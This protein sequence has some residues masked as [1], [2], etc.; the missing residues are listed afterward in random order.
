[1]NT[2][3]RNPADSSVSSILQTCI[4][5]GRR[6]RKGR[7]F[8]FRGDTLPNSPPIPMQ[9]HEVAKCIFCAMRHA[10]MLRRSIIVAA[11]IGTMQTLVNQGDVLFDVFL[12]GQLAVPLLWKIPLT[13]M[14]PFGVATF[15][16][17]T[18]SRR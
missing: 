17:M 5:C 2:E 6:L 12:S 15:G 4:Q 7:A 13:Y 16:A 14:I 10:S 8:R 9:M 18:I 3:R 1:M 11:L